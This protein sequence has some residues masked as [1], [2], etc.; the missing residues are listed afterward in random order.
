MGR[1]PLTNI[2]VERYRSAFGEDAP[3]S[4][5]DRQIGEMSCRGCSIVE[6]AMKT[7]TSTAT[8]SR[9]RKSIISRMGL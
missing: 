9:R 5:L 2:S 8:V 3:F 6:I 1:N 7:C 4:E